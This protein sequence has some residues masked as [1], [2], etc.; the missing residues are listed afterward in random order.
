MDKE[1]DLVI[2]LT[3]LHNLITQNLKSA[4]KEVERVGKVSITIYNNIG[5]LFSFRELKSPSFCL[6]IIN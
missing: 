4:L 1:F 5:I 3:T 2:S 6:Q